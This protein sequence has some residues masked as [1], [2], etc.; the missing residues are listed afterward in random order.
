ML[1]KLKHDRTS[2]F[3]INNIT[4]LLQWFTLH[5][6]HYS[7]GFIQEKETI[8]EKAFG[9]SLAPRLICGQVNIYSP[10][11]TYIFT[12]VCLYI[13]YIF[14]SVTLQGVKKKKSSL[15]VILEFADS[16]PSDISVLHSNNVC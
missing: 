9:S 5:D 3:L 4:V 13:V 7:V 10:L 6:M 11:I 15:N 1:I 16:G 12:F 14:K 2:G 8:Q